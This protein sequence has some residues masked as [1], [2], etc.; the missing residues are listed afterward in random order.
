MQSAYLYLA[1]AIIAEVAATTA[2]KASEQ[3]TKPIPTLIV[4]IGYGTAF[5]L[6]TLV[7]RTLPVGVTYAIWSGLGIVLVGIAG[8]VV[9]KQVPD[10]PAIIGM[11][12]I[13][14]G[15]IVLNLYSKNVGH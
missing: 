6:L 10:L 14:A 4:A 5:Y 8:A 1:I 2:L 7:L 9:Y 11:G 3:F 13:I 12:L 15:V